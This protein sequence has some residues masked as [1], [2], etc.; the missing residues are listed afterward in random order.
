MNIERKSE[1][2]PDFSY[3]LHKFH[4][5]FSKTL[6]FLL[7]LLSFSPLFCRHA[8][9]YV[10]DVTSQITDGITMARIPVSKNICRISATKVRIGVLFIT[11]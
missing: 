3:S 4:F 7:H 1:K 9:Q 6:R 8:L 11:V 2:F 10:T 5:L